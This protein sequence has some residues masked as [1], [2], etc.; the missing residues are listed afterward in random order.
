MNRIKELRKSKKLTQV[1]FC[2]IIGITQGALS[3]WEN[4]RYEPDLKSLHKMADYFEVTVDYLLGRESDES[5]RSTQLNDKYDNQLSARD[6]KDVAKRLDEVIGDMERNEAL[7]FDGEPMDE[8][9]KELVKIAIE[10][11]IKMAKVMA[12][13]DAKKDKN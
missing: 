3:G 9:T 7:M 8:E 2:K 13:K 5:N 1:A 10:E 12:K 11:S 4:E 6:R